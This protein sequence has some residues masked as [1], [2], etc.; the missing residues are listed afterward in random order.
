MPFIRTI[1]ETEARDQLA[2]LYRQLAYPDGSIDEAYRALSL[3]PALLAADA[4]MHRTTMY[5][6]SPL[7]RI[8]RELL[9]LTVSRLNRCERCYRHHSTRYQELKTRS[10]SGKEIRQQLDPSTSPREEALIAFAEKLTREPHA[11]T[12][13]DIDILRK[14]GLDDRAILDACNTVAYFNYANR[15]SLG[16]GLS[17]GAAR[18]PLD[19]TDTNESQSDEGD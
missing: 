15:M 12:A 8:E 16:L 7:S 19:S 2:D 3:N 1:D 5:G 17:S 18:Q 11:V 4:A 14:A 6:D 9:A 10:Q 13:S